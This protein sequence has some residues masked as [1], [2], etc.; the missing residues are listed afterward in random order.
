M[1]RVLLITREPWRDDSNEGSVLSSWFEDQPMEL[2]QIFCKPGMPDNRCCKRYFQLTDKMAAK[3]LL[4]GEAMGQVID[5]SQETIGEAP[6]QN[7]SEEEKKSFYDFF[8]RNNWPSFFLMRECLWGLANWKSKALETFA[9]DFAPDVIVAPLSYSRY[10]MA[11]QRWVAKRLK[12]PMAGIVWDDLYS[13]KQWNFSPVFWLNRLLQRHSVKKTVKQCQHLYTLSPQHAEAFGQQFGCEFGVLPKVGIPAEE[14]APQTEETVRLIYAGGIYYGRMNTLTQI[15]DTLSRLNQ[16]GV[17]CRLDVY[18][19]SP[20]AQSL[21]REGVCQVH[22]AVSAQE[23]KKHYHASHVA[24]HVE[25]FERSAERLTKLSFSSKIVDCL[26]SGCAILAVCPHGNCG[27]RYLKEHQ[28]AV[29]VDQL[30]QLPA[31]VE[32]LVKDEQQRNLWKERADALM[33]KNHRPEVVKSLI[34]QQLSMVA[35]KEQNQ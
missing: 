20:D 8:R 28:A 16:E 35:G 17:S 23:L 24:I 29:C 32:M 21:A 14:A 18:T 2:A 19:N 7:A 27:Y 26:S 25:G 6:V 9:D 13:L 12:K 22:Q 31:S 15:V 5:L 3:N 4:K 33:Q 34:H 10:V 1:L 30:T 11:I